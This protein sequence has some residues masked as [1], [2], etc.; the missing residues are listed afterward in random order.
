VDD[1][2]RCVLEDEP[3]SRHLITRVEELIHL[4]AVSLE[5]LAILLRQVIDGGLDDVI[6]VEVR[7]SFHHA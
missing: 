7:G 4:G 5:C 2:Q 1:D 6:L 3:M